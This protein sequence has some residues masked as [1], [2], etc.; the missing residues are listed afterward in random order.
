MNSHNVLAFD[1]SLYTYANYV[2]KAPAVNMRCRC[3]LD[4]P[5][6]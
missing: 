1:I 2:E 5:H 4:T 6:A 3:F